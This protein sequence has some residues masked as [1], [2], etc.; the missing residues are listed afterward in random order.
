MKVGFLARTLMIMEKYWNKLQDKADCWWAVTQKEF[1]EM[2]IENNYNKIIFHQEKRYLEKGEVSGN[3]F[4]PITPGPL[5]LT[6]Q[7][8][9]AHTSQPSLCIAPHP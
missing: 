2:L 6:H 5:P 4:I 8:L 3:P 7:A 9:P 1:Y